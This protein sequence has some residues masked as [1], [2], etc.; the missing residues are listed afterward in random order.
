MCCYHPKMVLLFLVLISYVKKK[1]IGAWGSSGVRVRSFL[2]VDY[3]ELVEA[4]WVVMLFSFVLFVLSI[5]GHSSEL[6]VLSEW[7]SFV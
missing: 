3:G 6:L 2:C 1:K 7:G 4:M 5:E